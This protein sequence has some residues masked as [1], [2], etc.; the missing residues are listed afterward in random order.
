MRLI[1]S[2]GIAF[3]TETG[4]V[5]AFDINTGE[6]VSMLEDT[7]YFGKS[8]SFVGPNFPQIFV[9]CVYSEIILSSLYHTEE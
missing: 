6:Q 9:A 1:S 7:Y 8:I 4:K 2:E 3:V 5:R